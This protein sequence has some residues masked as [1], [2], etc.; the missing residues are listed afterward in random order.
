MRRASAAEWLNGLACTGPECAV[1]NAAPAVSALV[2]R[3]AAI[4][5]AQYLYVCL[6]TMPTF[7]A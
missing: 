6:L 7:V 2:A 4:R 1:N 3:A 5:I